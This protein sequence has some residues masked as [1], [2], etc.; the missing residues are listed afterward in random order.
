MADYLCNTYLGMVKS[1]ASIW[2]SKLRPAALATSITAMNPP[3]EVS[4]I[5]YAVCEPD[6]TEEIGRLLAKTFTRHDPP[7]VAV[8]ITPG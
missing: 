1:L 6:D 8:G 3:H 7:A 2:R 5:H 4:G